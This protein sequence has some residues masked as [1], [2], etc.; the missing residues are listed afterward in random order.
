[1]IVVVENCDEKVRKKKS[2]MREDR[3]LN[4]YHKNWK[5]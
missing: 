3:I 4:L 2:G 5:A 1:M